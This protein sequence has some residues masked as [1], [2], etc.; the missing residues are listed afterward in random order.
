[1]NEVLKGAAVQAVDS[2]QLNLHIED[3]QLVA[4]LL[5]YREG[6]Q[7]DDFALT[8][9]RIGIL[10]LKQA[11]GRIDADVVKNEGDKLLAAIE[12]KLG[13]HQETVQDQVAST[14]KE[15]F[16]PKDGRF[17]GR[18]EQLVKNG[19]ELEQLLRRQ[20]GESDSEL[21]KTLAGS[22]GA[23]SALMKLLSPTET[24]GILASISNTV[25][26]SL[27]E[28][29]EQILQEFS[30]D[31]ESG[32]LARMI[33][34]MKEK[35]GELSKGLA[36]KVDEVVSEFSLDKPDSALSRL[37]K[38]V[39]AAQ[40]KISSEFSLDEESS[41]LARMKKSLEGLIEKAGKDN[42]E[43]RAQVRESLA[44]LQARKE[45]SQRSTRH[46]IE[47]EEILLQFVTENAQ[48]AGDIVEPT[49]STTGLI[50]N[51]KV[52]DAV[53][54]IGAEQIAAG[55]RIVIE[56]KQH[57]SYNVK[58]ALDEIDTARKNRDAKVGLFVLSKR[59]APVGLAPLTRYGNDILVVWDPED[60]ITDVILSAGL[61]LG[62]ALCAREEVQRQGLEVDMERL[63]VAMLDIEQQAKG[64]D[65]I[66][67]SSQTIQSAAKRIDDRARI[68]GE[69]LTRS[70]G[71]LTEEV[72]AIKS[73]MQQDESDAQ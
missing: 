15:Y 46:G 65:E 68:I 16:D 36:D 4:E 40:A 10:A 22:F 12:F 63:Q 69:K 55:A 42:E 66:R 20:I 39:V 24:N 48:H 44:S 70:A 23:N 61:S 32:A 21:A 47:F 19:G 54:T 26:K 56:A 49:G 8:A 25:G 43:F 35:H 14:L 33:R 5:A 30:L 37:V 52:G 71:I 41:A 62:K 51:C 27:G 59:L 58:A 18:V 34:E 45:E 3:P 29:R 13:K 1:M 28:Q 73:F 9:L 64:L 6:A 50:K 11:Q 17:N 31:N 67:T 7:R 57:A 53:L 60:P 2:V 38:E 72:N